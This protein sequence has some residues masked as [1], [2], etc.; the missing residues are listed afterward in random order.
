VLQ[1]KAVWGGEAG[2]W[3]N[4]AV[5]FAIKVF[6]LIH[7]PAAPAPTLPLARKALRETHHRV[8]IFFNASVLLN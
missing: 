6:E 8:K 3:G 1:E 5:R 7:S 2:G 4:W